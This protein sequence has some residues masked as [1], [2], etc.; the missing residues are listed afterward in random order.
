MRLALF[1]IDGTLISTKGAGMRAFYW[2]LQKLF[3]IR[4][5]NEVI[6]PDGMTDPLILKSLLAHFDMSDRWCIQTQETLFSC[7]LECLEDEMSRARE[8]GQIKILPGVDDLLEELAALED[9]CVGLATGNLERGAGI[10][11][12]KAGL[13]KYFRFGGYGSDSEDR[14]G[15]VRIGIQRGAR[16]IAPAPVE[17][18]FVIGDTPLDIIHGRAAGARTI[19]VASARY[20]VNDL[21]REKPDLVVPDLSATDSIVSFMRNP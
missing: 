8:R 12:D 1:D 16:I 4:V 3:G 21:Y 17:E 14:T 2:A 10:K 11:L 18:A 7:Y 13:S 6:R 9:F 15:L 19:A 20:S 5:E